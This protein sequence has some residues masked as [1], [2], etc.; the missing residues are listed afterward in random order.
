[1]SAG[2]IWEAACNG[3]FEQTAPIWKYHIILENHKIETKDLIF[4]CIQIT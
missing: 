3:Q 2:A 1:M 4:H